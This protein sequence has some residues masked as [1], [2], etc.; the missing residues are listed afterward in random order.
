M[1]LSLVADDADILIANKAR[2]IRHVESE[3]SMDVDVVLATVTPPDQ[4][5]W[6][7]T[8]CWS[9]AL[10]G[11]DG[12]PKIRIRT[13]LEEIREFYEERRRDA[14]L[15][16]V[17]PSITDVRSRWYVFSQSQAIPMRNVYTGA[18]HDVETAAIF[19]MDGREGITSEIVWLRSAH[20]TINATERTERWVAFLDALR[21][22]DVDG[23]LS[24][25]APSVQGAVR[26][27]FDAEPPFVA[28]DG[29][30][31]MRRF[32]ERLFANASVLDISVVTSLVKEW[33][34]FH[35]LQWRV[36]LEQGPRRDTEVR[37][38][39]AEYMPFDAEGRFQARCGYGT[40]F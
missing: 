33:F 25:M 22:Q 39:T 5:T 11:P 36:R 6:A 28:I 16:E 38:R 8:L 4:L 21:K 26:D 34:V 9:L 29:Q 3:T 1:T 19:L 20:V 13:S 18:L 32:Y 7:K 15:N 30:A 12:K 35:D 27:D 14:I 24:L 2:C 17:R 23:L 31:E 37:F 10:P 40:G